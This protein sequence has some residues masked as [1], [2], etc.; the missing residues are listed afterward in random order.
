M[1]GS[2]GFSG[3]TNNV[4]SNLFSSTKNAQLSQREL[5]INEFLE[6]LPKTSIG[7]VDYKAL[8]KLAEEKAN[9]K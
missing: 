3:Y 9:G 2:G 1:G 5:E 8:E 7:K 6:S 4:K